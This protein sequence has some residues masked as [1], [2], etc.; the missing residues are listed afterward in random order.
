MNFLEVKTD[1]TSNSPLNPFSEFAV[2]FPALTIFSILISEPTE[3]L[4]GSSV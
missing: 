1:V 3:R 4:C 2:V